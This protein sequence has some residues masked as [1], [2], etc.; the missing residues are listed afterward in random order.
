[1]LKRRDAPYLPVRTKLR[2]S[3]SDTHWHR[4]TGRA[5]LQ[6]CPTCALV[7]AK[8]GIS[9]QSYLRFLCFLL[10]IFCFPKIVAAGENLVLKPDSLAHYIQ[11]FNS[12]EDENVT[13]AI[14][15]AGSWNWLQKEIPLF[16]CPD[17]EVEDMYYFRW[18]SFRKH[19][20]KT[21][22]GFVF[23]EF[24]TPVSWAGRSEERRGGKEG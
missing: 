4:E 16:Q 3:K 12:M 24:L 22:N 21:P 1:M 11:H 5:N 18:W 7:H 6:V 8:L 9:I 13:N 19:I 15:N 20:V 10:F 23:T 17:Q 2:S 14:S